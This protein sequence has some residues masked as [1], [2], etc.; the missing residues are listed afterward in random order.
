M[1]KVL[2]IMALF[3]ISSTVVLLT[4]CDSNEK[5]IQNA[6]QKVREANL[7]LSELLKETREEAREAVREKEIALFKAEC[8]L[9]IQENEKRIAELRIKINKNGKAADP[10]YAKRIDVLQDENKGLE[11]KLN[12][13]DK[14]KTPWEQFKIDFVKDVNNL[15]VS[16]QNI[17]VDLD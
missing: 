6:E 11:R 5:K 2:F 16:L 12:E 7:E 17:N 4:S 8:I 13:F 9:Q 14:N 10:L 3:A 1:K 15:V